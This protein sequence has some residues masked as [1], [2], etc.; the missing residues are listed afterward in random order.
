[1]RAFAC[2]LCALV[3][4]LTRATLTRSHE[5]IAR[6]EDFNAYTVHDDARAQITTFMPPMEYWP[7]DMAAMFVSSRTYKHEGRF[8]MTVFL[9]GNGCSEE[10]ISAF[11]APYLDDEVARRS[12]ADILRK[13]AAGTHDHQWFYYN[14]WQHDMLYLN[15]KY[16]N[17]DTMH[18]AREV[19]Q[20]DHEVNKRLGFC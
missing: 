1:M 18:Y 10:M 9:Y 15:G 4:A 7:A 11:M 2:A 14:V 19:E 8:R 13:L 16:Q 17:P 3:H 12:N 20:K 5:K 6:H